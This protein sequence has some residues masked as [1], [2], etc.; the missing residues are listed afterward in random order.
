MKT[1][2]GNAVLRFFKAGVAIVL[3]VCGAQ[4]ALAAGTA[5]NTILENTVTVNFENAG[6]LAMTAVTATA[7]ITVNLVEAAPSVAFNAAASTS[8]LE[9]AE[10]D[11]ITLVYDVTSNANG[12]D[13]YELVVADS[14]TSNYGTSTFSPVSPVSVGILGATTVAE[15]FS[16]LNTGGSGAGECTVNGTGTCEIQVPNDGPIGSEGDINSLAAGDTVVLN[17]GSTLTCTVVSV[18]DVAGAT[19]AASLSTLEVD[20]CEDT[21][22]GAFALAIGDDIFESKQITIST[23]LGNLTA[24]NVDGST[25]ISVTPQPVGGSAGT[26]DTNATI[27][28]KAPSVSV[29]K[30]VRNVTTPVA[31]TDP[32]AGADIAIL[33]YDG[34]G[35]GTF[36]ANGVTAAPGDVLEYAVIVRRD[37]GNVK[38]IR[39]TDPLQI[40]TTYQAASINVL[41]AEA[42]GFTCSNTWTC[43]VTVTDGTVD[44]ADDGSTTAGDTGFFSGGTITAYG[45]SG[46]DETDG[47]NPGGTLGNGEVS[48]I[49]YRVTVDN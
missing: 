18:T 45:G 2:T 22:G 3:L 37:L 43:D 17:N 10:G 35:G 46:A 38:D 9:G 11:V 31:G 25:T 40:F 49:T 34:T 39:I 32:G 21:G 20:S 13:D 4:S 8:P 44:A 16:I 24:A 47:T 29:F 33:T 5:A 30:L 26:P 6:G 28:I 42:T 7:S 27:T 12:E 19:S 41:D 48:V 23:T 1:Q 15:A 36:Y 14:S